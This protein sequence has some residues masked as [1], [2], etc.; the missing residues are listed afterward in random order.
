MWPPD[1]GHLSEPVLEVQSRR[2]KGYKDQRSSGVIVIAPS[3]SSEAVVLAVLD[4]SDEGTWDPSSTSG[5]V[6]KPGGRIIKKRSHA[7]KERRNREV[8]A[9]QHASLFLSA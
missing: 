2:L 8:S 1:C 9:N 6:A 5:G 3:E 4:V 7:L